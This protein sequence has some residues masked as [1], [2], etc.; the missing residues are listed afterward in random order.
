MMEG[1]FQQGMQI[2]QWLLS[3][4]LIV[5]SPLA[6]QVSVLAES[7]VVPDDT[8]E[9][10]NSVVQDLEGQNQL[11]EG[12]AVRGH[13]L[14]HSFWEFNVAEGHGVYF[15]HPI[16]VRS[17]LTRVTGDN[18]SHIFGRLGVLGEANLF[19]LNPNGIVFG[20]NASLDVSGS[21][22]ASTAAAIP[23]EDG[24]FSALEPQGNSLL[25]VAPEVS[26]FNYLTADSGDIVSAAQL[27]A[28]GDL[29]LIGHS[30]HLRGALTAGEDLRLLAQDTVT[31]RDT[32]TE[33][34]LAQASETLT[35]RGNQG[36]DIRALNP[37]RQP[38][39]MSRGDLT[40][41][42]DGEIAVDAYFESGSNFAIESISEGIAN[43]VSPHGVIISATDTVDIA[44]NYTGA[45]WLIESQADVQVQGEVEINDP[46]AISSFVG[47][48]T[49][50]SSRPGLTV[51]AGQNSLRYRTLNPITL[52]I[53]TTSL[54]YG[55]ITLAESV[56]IAEG[57]GHILLS[58][59]G[60]IATNGVTANPR[61]APGGTLVI[62]SISGDIT[63]HDI[64]DAAS[65]SYESDASN[66]GTITLTSI[67]GNITNHDNLNANSYSSDG[68]SGNG[69]AISISSRS[70]DIINHGRLNVDTRSA[71]SD[72]GNG[73][74]I[75]ISSRSGDITNHGRLNARSLSDST[76]NGGSITIS[77]NS[78]NITNYRPLDAES[79][80]AGR[81]TSDGGTISISSVSGD[82]TNNGFLK[83]DLFSF[84]GGSGDGGNI[85]ISSS[86][87]DITNR[88]TLSSRLSAFQG[89]QGNG[90]SIT[91]SSNSG[92]ITNYRGLDVSSS[93]AQGNIG[94]GG[95]IAISSNSGDVSDGDSRFRLDASSSSFYGDT[96]D[97]GTIVIASRSGNISINRLEAN[98]FSSYGDV[99][100]GGAIA[101]ASRSGN[102][103]TDY[104]D[105]SS[106]STYGES[107]N[108]GT[109]AISSRSGDITN[110]DGLNAGS[111]S[112]HS[113]AGNGGNVFLS[114]GFGNIAT[115]YSI[116]SGSSA[117][118]D[119]GNGGNV[120]IASDSGDIS[121]NRLNSSSIS[122]NG[123]RSI[124]D[125]SS[126]PLSV[127]LDGDAGNGG[128]I[129]ISSISGDIFITEDIVTASYSNSGNAGNGGAISIIA[130][131]GQIIG[132]DS[133][134]L[135]F[136]LSEPGG[137][138]GEGG[139]INLTAQDAISGITIFTL[140]PSGDSGTVN[141][142][143]LGD[144]S[145]QDLQLVVTGQVQVLSPI[146]QIQDI[147]PDPQVF[148]PIRVRS[149]TI[150]LDLTN[151]GQ[152]GDV[153][154]TS[155]GD[156]TLN[157]V[158]IL[159]DANGRTNAGD[160]TI[161]N[162][163]DVRLNNT[164]ILSDTNAAGNGGNII[165]QNLNSLTLDNS[166]LT[167]NTEGLG[168]D[169]GSI[170]VQDVGN[171]I[172]R[173]NSLVLADAVEAANGGTINI[174][175]DFVIAIPGGGSDI[176]ANAVG[177]SG[178]KI[179]ITATG[180]FGFNALSGFTTE[181]LRSNNS[182]DISASSQ[183]G[184]AGNVTIDSLLPNVDR[185][186]DDLAENLINPD[187]LIGDSCIARGDTPTQG[188][189]ILTG[190]SGL[191]QQPG[192]TSF[193]TFSTV[194][195]EAIPPVP[196]AEPDADTWLDN[197]LTEP[198][199]VYQLAD[200][201]LVLSHECDS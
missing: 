107:A 3:S 187:M 197:E 25:T 4:I 41:L 188:S 113:N 100:N 2:Y 76:G 54:G 175:T 86:S 129:A 138:T 153:I 73:G 20:E 16:D 9:A 116:S 156:L 13:N 77:S 200:G 114:S 141:I 57:S 81:S 38:S 162:A 199:G 72:A 193:S 144:L 90:G 186:L 112:W 21:F 145:I 69:G 92:D 37:T 96:G 160:I 67:S 95:T 50:L 61:S 151:I 180:I 136:S 34:F 56:A 123:S 111:S 85:A 159:S 115:Q 143:G 88:S 82:I 128:T 22:Y 8:L 79:F 75:T 122:E 17:I 137:M 1:R 102:I 198:D 62:S 170:F 155:L 124:L 43:V 64:L 42:S 106:S 132:E 190:S 167:T 176:I 59:E 126:E 31:V 169:A 26:F 66:G 131:A 185:G 29:T 150:D 93:S 36:V 149:K 157:N 163:G 101:I 178:G 161:Y 99:G 158:A 11:I 30:I 87:G 98:V 104:L 152:S 139:D 164:Q 191:P 109:I 84:G 83:T 154:I 181:E 40:L 182:S 71:T 39:F 120:V 63:N 174:D 165:L 110:Y 52:P 177:G 48:D 60:D 108:G 44:A 172:L 134:F 19:L 6:W 148:I 91:I 119:A 68:K 51:R 171:F 12:G 183:F 46:S 55:G 74:A 78:G 117:Y 97:G 14:F 147:D 127:T 173:G 65:F 140:S 10:E 189:F 121:I 7:E 27:V 47:A 103:T 130:E 196:M 195:V 18:P 58:A 23:L 32:T 70:G 35:V 33:P 80:S 94:N 201:R 184:Q 166:T 28:G 194:G 53:D 15:A 135:A 49:T 168:G 179:N 105:V 24:V 118:L 125:Y 89:S 45:S 192:D 133:D 5:G 142:Q 146:L